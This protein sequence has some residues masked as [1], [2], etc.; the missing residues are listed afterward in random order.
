MN[1]PFVHN[2]LSTWGTI[3]YYTFSTWEKC[4]RENCN[5]TIRIFNMTFIRRYWFLFGI[6][7]ALVLGYLFPGFGTAVNPEG[8]SGT[9]AVILLFFIA[10]LTLPSDSIRSGVRNYR[11]HLYVQFFIF[12]CIPVFVFCTTLPFRN[13]IDRKVLT[14]LYAVAIL[15]TTV[16][17]CIVFTQLSGGNVVGS[18]FNSALANILGILI[19]PLLLS[20]LLQGAGVE[21]SL[22]ELLSIL[23][24]LGYKMLAPVAAGQLVRRAFK[25]AVPKLKSPLKTASNL[26]II[27]VI[28]FSFAKAAANPRFSSNLGK[29]LLPFLYLA[30]A[31]IIF[32]FGAYRGARLV[33]LSKE[34][35]IAA[36]YTASQKSAAM[37]VPF[38]SSF[39]ADSPELL[40][41]VLLPV[42]FYHSFQLF[43][44][45]VVKTLPFI[46]EDKQSEKI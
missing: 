42:I 43:T 16:S 15:P 31:N 20:L 13:L 37:G 25:S 44:A 35:R 30:G 33:G 28:F 8:I 19:S 12:V 41:V 3:L 7:C 9:V 32:T 39:F 26:L 1:F 10:G 6:L 34:N 22:R 27:I 21:I 38:V 11:L 45:G 24:S 2:Y 29:M 40:G 17:S 23:L 14:G 36:L 5:C 4:R 18:M 46:R